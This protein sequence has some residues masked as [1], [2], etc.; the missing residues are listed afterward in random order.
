MEV[1][2]RSLRAQFIHDGNHNRNLEFNS[3]IAYRHFITEFETG[4]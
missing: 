1:E 3:V 2:L 4:Y